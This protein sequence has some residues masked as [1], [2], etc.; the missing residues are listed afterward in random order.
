MPKKIKRR[1]W[2]VCNTPDGFTPDDFLAE[3][4]WCRGKNAEMLKRTLNE[5]CRGKS[6]DE[7]AAEYGVQVKTLPFALWQVD[8]RG[9]YVC[10]Y[11][12]RQSH[13]IH[14]AEDLTPK[15]REEVLAHEL[16]HFFLRHNQLRYR[17]TVDQ[18][19]NVAYRLCHDKPEWEAEADEFGKFLMSLSKRK[20]TT[21]RNVGGP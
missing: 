16:G 18:D 19:G 8:Q 13:V 12:E 15:E 17:R 2:R 14:L 10:R 11:G 3:D 1:V 9:R 21:S 20:R 5:T 4:K 7:I 6:L